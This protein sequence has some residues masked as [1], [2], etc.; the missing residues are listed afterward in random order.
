MPLA[1]K[2]AAI[3]Q[4][5]AIQGAKKRTRP[6]SGAKDTSLLTESLFGP[7]PFHDGHEGST[8]CGFLSAPCR[9][10]RRGGRSSQRLC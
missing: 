1:S 10:Q 9:K 6:A 7:R 5:S 8:R 2:Q 4:L 3:L